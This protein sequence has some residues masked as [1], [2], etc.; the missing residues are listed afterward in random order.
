MSYRIASAQ[1]RDSSL[2]ALQRHEKS[3]SEAR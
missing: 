2:I 1:S 3:L